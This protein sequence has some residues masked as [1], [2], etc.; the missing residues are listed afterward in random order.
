[1]KRRFVMSTKTKAASFASALLL[2]LSIALGNPALAD[3]DDDQAK[4][5]ALVAAGKLISPDEARQKA[6]AAKPGTV[7]DVDLE[8]SWR[9]GYQYEVEIVDPE[10]QKWEVYIDAKTGQVR[11]TRRD[12]FD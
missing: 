11:S 7:T 5:Q 2:S 9:S 1:M 3:D 10:L 8:H 4:V 12:W 6:L